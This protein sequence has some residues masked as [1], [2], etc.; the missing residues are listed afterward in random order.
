MEKLSKHKRAKTK[1]RIH[2][3]WYKEAGSLVATSVNSVLLLHK[4]CSF[5]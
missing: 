5:R 2:E 4:K 3:L 1:Q